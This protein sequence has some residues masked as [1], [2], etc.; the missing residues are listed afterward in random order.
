MIGLAKPQRTF[1]FPRGGVPRRERKG[2]E[3][4]SK[5]DGKRG[6]SRMVVRGMQG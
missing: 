3:T 1:A 2:E 4:A 5:E 6:K